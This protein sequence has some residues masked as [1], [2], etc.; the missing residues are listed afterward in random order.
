MAVLAQPP[1]T[2]KILEEAR[3]GRDSL[4]RVEHNGVVFDLVVTPIKIIVYSENPEP[5]GF[6]RIGGPN[7]G[8]IWAE[9]DI[10]AEYGLGADDKYF[11]IPIQ[12]GFKHPAGPKYED[13]LLYLL[14]HLLQ[15]A[16]AKPS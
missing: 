15:G 14:K 6:L 2:G 11:V 3:Q 7:S 5:I 4:F 13:P 1:M 9:S 8:A 10:I 12:H 16:Q